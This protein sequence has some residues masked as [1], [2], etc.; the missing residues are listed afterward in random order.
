MNLTDATLI[1][2]LAI[3]SVIEILFWL[4]PNCTVSMR[5]KLRE[6]TNGI[7]SYGCRH[8]QGRRC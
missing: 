5:N 6:T 2:F 7:Y 8:Y 3:G 4:C 1:T